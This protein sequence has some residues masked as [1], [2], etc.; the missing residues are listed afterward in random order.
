VVHST[1]ADIA[2]ADTDLA[3]AEIDD[4]EA[5]DRYRQATKRAS[6]KAMQGS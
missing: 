6:N 1:R 5:L 2:E 4:A 3:A